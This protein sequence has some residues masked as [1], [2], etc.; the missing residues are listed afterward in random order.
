MLELKYCQC[1]KIKTRLARYCCRCSFKHIRNRKKD[2]ELD[3]IEDFLA[4]MTYKA[5]GIKC[6]LTTERVRQIVCRV[7]REMR[8]GLFVMLGVDVKKVR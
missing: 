8:G 1:G 7:D 5:M 6:S 4:G 3:I 2:R